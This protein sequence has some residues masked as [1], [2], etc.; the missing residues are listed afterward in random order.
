MKKTK[1]FFIS[2]ALV[3]MVVISGC[4]GSLSGTYVPDDGHGFFDKLEFISGN[5][6]DIYT[7][8]TTV[9]ASYKIDGNKIVLG[10]GGQVLT[11]DE[12]GCLDGGKMIGKYC[13]E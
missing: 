8:G 6:V 3:C 2:F 4:S 1:L 7:M 12:N 5:K 11:I 10:I 9:E 13:K